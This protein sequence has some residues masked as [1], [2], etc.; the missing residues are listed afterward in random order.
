[1]RINSCWFLGTHYFKLDEVA[2]YGDPIQFLEDACESTLL[3]L[4][5]FQESQLADFAQSSLSFS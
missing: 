2:V 3:R 4:D 5:I 1:M